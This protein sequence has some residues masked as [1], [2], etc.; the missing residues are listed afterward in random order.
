MDKQRVDVKDWL[1][2]LIGIELRIKSKRAQIAKYREMATRATSTT[3]AVRVSGTPG[4][5][6]VED[7][8]VALCDVE[9]EALAELAALQKFR[10]DAMTVIHAVR[11]PRRR[12]I[13]EMRYVTGWKL[14]KI[15]DEMHYQVRWVQVLHG[16]ALEDARAALRQ[17]PE[18]VRVYALDTRGKS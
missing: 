12:D 10:Q 2:G 9:A 16:E 18:I 7:A 8:V 15:A 11:D 5:S 1:Y 4:R 6:R 17:M 14:S 13:L 3:E